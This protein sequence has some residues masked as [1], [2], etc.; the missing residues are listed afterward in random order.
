MLSPTLY[1]EGR[2]VVGSERFVL[3]EGQ[4]VSE[5][6]ATAGIPDQY[7]QFATSTVFNVAG[8][9]VSQTDRDGLVSENRYDVRGQLIETRRQGLDDRGNLV[10]IVSR[11]VY[12]AIGRTVA[13]TDPYLEGTAEPIHGSRT[14]FDGGWEKQKNEV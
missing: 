6:V 4:F 7:R 10:W 8:Q 2:R 3:P 1:D 12:D 11:T 5:E 14:I 9:V 13:Q